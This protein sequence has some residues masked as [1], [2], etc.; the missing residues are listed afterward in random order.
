M[1]GSIADRESAELINRLYGVPEG[2]P[3]DQG[4]VI[5]VT[6]TPAG[7]PAS[8]PAWMSGKPTL[9][10]LTDAL[11]ASTTVTDLYKLANDDT[12]KDAVASLKPEEVKTLRDAYKTF[13]TSLDGKVKLDTFDGQVI[14]LVGIDW[15]HSDAYDADGV[16]LH[17]RTEREPEKLTKAL[18]SS[19]PVVTF[20][21]RLRELP[22]E[23]KPLRV[24][25]SLVPVRDPERAARGQKIWQV[26]QMP[27]ARGQ[28]DGSVPF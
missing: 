23:S 15:W 20:C 22:S 26:K 10:N 8:T 11:R 7:K 25:L 4:R 16:S 13:Q 12:F 5:R 19:A 17:I 14:N 2:T 24:M 9:V 21:N 27:P 6:E 3:F 1:E 18:T 28:S